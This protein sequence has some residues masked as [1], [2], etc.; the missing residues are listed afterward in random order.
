MSLLHGDVETSKNID[1]YVLPK[2]LEQ[3]VIHLYDVD[4]VTVE[5][6][7][8]LD[9]LTTEQSRTELYINIADGEEGYHFGLE[10]FLEENIHLVTD[11]ADLKEAVFRKVGIWMLLESK[12]VSVMLVVSVLI[13]TLGIA[14]M[15]IAIVKRHRLA[16]EAVVYGSIGS[17]K[18]LRKRTSTVRKKSEDGENDSNNNSN[19]T[20]ATEV[21]FFPRYSVVNKSWRDEGKEKK[22]RKSIQNNKDENRAESPTKYVDIKIHSQKGT[23]KVKG[24]PTKQSLYEIISTLRFKTE[25]VNN[26]TQKMEPNN[27]TSFYY[28]GNQSE[29][30]SKY[31]L[32][33]AKT[34]AKKV[35][36][37]T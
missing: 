27:Q 28:Q 16:I 23:K 37:N 21:A 8:P 22:T 7:I 4:T 29:G 31:D 2:V 17:L 25:Q 9:H 35:R 13:V 5:G 24:S 19:L 6:D 20:T 33:L 32:T 30:S 3:M 36:N 12:T 26:M 18:R 10:G 1:D 11:E 15:I 34:L 14:T